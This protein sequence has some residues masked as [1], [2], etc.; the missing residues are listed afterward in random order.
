MGGDFLLA[1]GLVVPLA[2]T[3]TRGG[4]VFLGGEFTSVG[5]VAVSNIA[6]WNGNTTRLIS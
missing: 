6:R 5:G 4:L 1:G 2:I 3:V